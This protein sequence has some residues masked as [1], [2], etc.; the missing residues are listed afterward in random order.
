MSWP[1]LER[2]CFWRESECNLRFSFWHVLQHMYVCTGKCIKNVKAKLFFKFNEDTWMIYFNNL[3]Y[4]TSFSLGFF[5][6]LLK[7]I[8]KYMISKILIKYIYLV[9][10]TH[11][12]FQNCFKCRP[13]VCSEKPFCTLYTSVVPSCY[14]SLVAFLLA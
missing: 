1:A 2:R 6:D 9:C 13:V 14:V 5:L 7:Y 11:F 12:C 3:V 10:R 8:M 4:S